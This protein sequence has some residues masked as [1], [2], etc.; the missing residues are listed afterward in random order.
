[1]GTR[2]ETTLVVALA[3]GGGRFQK[4]ATGH[5]GLCSGGWPRLQKQH[6]DAGRI[7][8]CNDQHDSI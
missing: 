5:V 2:P 8:R 1:M 3:A 4:T 7:A 6:R